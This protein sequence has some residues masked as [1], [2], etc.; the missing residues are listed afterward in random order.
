MAVH[1]DVRI[2]LLSRF[3]LVAHVIV[4]QSL[5]RCGPLLLK[6]FVATYLILIDF[7]S[8]WCKRRALIYT[9]AIGVLILGFAPNFDEGK[10]HT[11]YRLS[12]F[13]FPPASKK[14]VVEKR[15]EV[16]TTYK[17]GFS[18][19]N[20]RPGDSSSPKTSLAFVR[21]LTLKCMGAL[22][23]FWNDKHQ[24]DLS[25]SISFVEL[26]VS[27]TFERLSR[28]ISL[29]KLGWKKFRCKFCNSEYKYSIRMLWSYF[30]FIW[31]RWQTSKAQSCS[32]WHS[33]TFSMLF[34]VILYVSKTPRPRSSGISN[35]TASTFFDRK[36]FSEREESEISCCL[37]MFY[38]HLQSGFFAFY[39]LVWNLRSKTYSIH[40]PVPTRLQLSALL[41]LGK[42]Q[43]LDWFYI[44]WSM[45]TVVISIPNRC[46]G[47]A[48]ENTILL[49]RDSITVMTMR[50]FTVWI[51]KF[52]LDQRCYF[53]E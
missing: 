36:A 3:C 11:L 26:S 17:T 32:A 5:V 30:R 44:I 21:I 48:R 45:F 51:L 27:Y 39:P 18:S 24:L 15:V 14:V 2:L 53:S 33:S 25:P 42:P 16:F 43:A 28:L 38:N 52:S 49:Y 22:S 13:V 23:I 7:P 6:V 37:E 10:P 40:G 29:S 12:V 47:R 34:I 20:I 4:Q 50:I 9:K 31:T 46:V 35:G 41:C 1:R 19:R 8:F